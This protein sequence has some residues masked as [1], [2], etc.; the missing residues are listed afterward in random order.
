[1]C[2]AISFTS[3]EHYFGRSFDLGRSYG[4]EVTFLPRRARL[5]LRHIPEMSEHYAVLGMAVVQEGFPLYFDAVN[6]HGLCAAALNFPHFA[7]YGKHSPSRPAVTSFEVI[8]WILSGCRCLG[9]A[10]EMLRGVTVTD[11][12][13]SEGYPASPLHWMIADRTG[14]I[15]LEVTDG[16]TR[17]YENELGVLSNSPDYMSQTENLRTYSSLL[18]SASPVAGDDASGFPRI[19]GGMSSPDRFV[20]SAYLVS[21]VPRCDTVDDGISQ[22]L[23][24]L[25]AVSVPRGCVSDGGG[26]YHFTRY[27]SCCAASR[28]IYLCRRHGDESLLQYSIAEQDLNGDHVSVLRR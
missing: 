7:S 13:F 25:G 5:C 8:P 6:E 27:V 20:R 26:G 22:A 2:T 24:I 18:Y 17:L 10:I 1:M 4:E 11:E 21:C 23:S 15:V 28:G 12:S 9:E 16:V 3:G 19:P 14:S